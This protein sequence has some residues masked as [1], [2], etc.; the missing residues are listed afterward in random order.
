M[1]IF[2]LCT[3]VQDWCSEEYERWAK[4]GGLSGRDCG[5]Q[6]K[7]AALAS[8]THEAGSET[9]PWATLILAS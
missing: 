3:L 2:V 5:I 6:V 4:A 7:T 1:I 9:V 8:G